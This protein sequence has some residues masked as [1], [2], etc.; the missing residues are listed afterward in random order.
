MPGLK[1]VPVD[2]LTARG[3]GLPYDVNNSQDMNG[4]P[5]LRKATRQAYV[6]ES[7]LVFRAGAH[8]AGVTFDSH[9]YRV[10]IFNVQPNKGL[11]HDIS[12]SVKSEDG[13]YVNVQGTA[14]VTSTIANAHVGYV[15][16]P[17][18]DPKTHTIKGNNKLFFNP[19]LMNF[20]FDGKNYY[21]ED[22]VTKINRSVDPKTNK[23]TQNGIPAW[24]GFNLVGTVKM[25]AFGN[26][27]GLVANVDAKGFF[28][29]KQQNQDWSMAEKGTI[30]GVQKNPQGGW[31]L[32]VSNR[33]IV[34]RNPVMITTPQGWNTDYGMIV[35]K[36]DPKDS[37][38]ITNGTMTINATKPLPFVY[39]G[40]GRI[41]SYVAP[42]NSSVI[43]EPS[44]RIGRFLKEGNVIF[45]TKEFLGGSVG[46]KVDW[47]DGQA[48]ETVVEL[49]GK[50]IS[51]KLVYPTILGGK[52][53]ALKEATG[54][55]ILN[56]YSG[57]TDNFKGSF[58]QPQQFA[59]VLGASSEARE[60]TLSIGKKIKGETRWLLYFT[61]SGF[62]DKNAEVN[63]VVKNLFAYVSGTSFA[64]TKAIEN[65]LSIN[66]VKFTPGITFGGKSVGGNTTPKYIY[67]DVRTIKLG[68]GT[69]S[70]SLW[71]QG[72]ITAS[73][74]K[75]TKDNISF[76][77]K[78]VFQITR[79]SANLQAGAIGLYL[80]T[81]GDG[82]NPIKNGAKYTETLPETHQ[83]TDYNYVNGFIRYR[84]HEDYRSENKLPIGRVLATGFSELMS[85]ELFRSYEQMTL[86]S[87]EASGFGL[88]LH[89]IG[90]NQSAKIFDPMKWTVANGLEVAGM[91]ITAGLSGYYSAAKIAQ[92]LEA[93]SGV[94]AEGA[95]TGGLLVNITSSFVSKTNAVIQMTKL[96]EAATAMTALK[97]SSVAFRIALA[98]GKAQ[99]AWGAASAGSTM[100][101]DFVVYRQID[102][103]STLAAGLNG[104]KMGFEFTLVTGTV[105]AVASRFLPATLGASLTKIADAG[106]S[107]TLSDAKALNAVSAT[108]RMAAVK[109]GAIYT[110][111]VS[112]FV[113]AK[114][115]TNPVVI[116]AVQN[117]VIN[118]LTGYVESH[119]AWGQKPGGWTINQGMKDASIAALVSLPFGL[120]KLGVVR[121]A[122]G[123]F[124]AAAYSSFAQNS[125]QVHSFYN[126]ATYVVVNNISGEIRDAGY[127]INPAKY[128]LPFFSWEQKTALRSI[129]G[130]LGGNVSAVSGKWMKRIVG[131]EEAAGGSAG[132]LQ[133]ADRAL[134]GETITKASTR[135]IDRAWGSIKEGVKS[136]GAVKG[137]TGQW[138]ILK[139]EFAASN[140][141]AWPITKVAQSAQ[142][143]I[144]PI[145]G[146]PATG[147][148]LYAGTGYVI[149]HTFSAFDDYVKNGGDIHKVDWDKANAFGIFGAVSALSIKGWNDKGRGLMSRALGITE[150]KGELSLTAFAAKP[151]LI[152]KTG[153]VSAVDFAIPADAFNMG[154][155]FADYNFG[156]KKWNESRRFFL[157]DANG[158]E[159]G[160]WTASA[161][162]KKTFF[163]MGLMLGPIL[164]ATSRPYSVSGKGPLAWAL[165]RPLAHGSLAVPIKLVAVKEAA[166]NLG[167]DKKFADQIAFVSLAFFPGVS[168]M[169]QY[170]AGLRKIDNQLAWRD[171]RPD[172][173]KSL[174]LNLQKNKLL[175]Q[176]LKQTEQEKLDFKGDTNSSKYQKLDRTQVDIQ[177]NIDQTNNRVTEYTVKV[178][179]NKANTAINKL[180]KEQQKLNE[181]LKNL[182]PKGFWQAAEKEQ[183]SKIM[184]DIAKTQNKINYFTNGKAVLEKLIAKAETVSNR[185]RSAK[186]KDVQAKE[187]QV[188]A[189]ILDIAKEIGAEFDAQAGKFKLVETVRAAGSDIQLAN[190]GHVSLIDNGTLVI[191]DPR[192]KAVGGHVG[193]GTF[194]LG[195]YA[196]DM[197]SFDHERAEL[198]IWFKFAIERN[199]MTSEEVDAL[200][201]GTLEGK[202]LG[203]RIREYANQGNFLQR[204]GRQK[205]VMN[206]F[207]VAHAEGLWAENTMPKMAASN[208]YEATID[209]KVNDIKFPKR[210]FD[211]FISSNGAA[212]SRADVQPEMTGK[213]SSEQRKAQGEGHDVTRAYA[214]TLSRAAKAIDAVAS[215]KTPE[216]KAKA[217]MQWEAANRDVKLKEAELDLHIANQ[218]LQFAE[219]RVTVEAEK[220][221]FTG[222]PVDAGMPTTTETSTGKEKTYA[223]KEVERL[224][225]KVA[226]Y[227][228]KVTVAE[229]SAKQAAGLVVADALLAGKQREIKNLTQKQADLLEKAQ[230]NP[231]KF[232]SAADA[233][234]SEIQKQ[235]GALDQLTADL[236]N[237]VSFD[238]TRRKG[239]IEKQLR[240][241]G[242]AEKQI[243]KKMGLESSLAALKEQPRTPETEK[244]IQSIEAKLSD[245][246][247]YVTPAKIVEKSQWEARLKSL[248]GKTNTPV[249]LL[250][251]Q[252]EKTT[253]EIYSRTLTHELSEGETTSSERVQAIKQTLA[254]LKSSQGVDIVEQRYVRQQIAEKQRAL[255]DVAQ[256][257]EAP[258][259]P[260]ENKSALLERKAS[261]ESEINQLKTMRRDIAD[262]EAIT[263][264][265]HL[266]SNTTRGLAIVLLEQ[267]D[268]KLE[269][270]MGEYR[271][272]ADIEQNTFSQENTAPLLKR[273]E[274]EKETRTKAHEAVREEIATKTAEIKQAERAQQ[275]T[276]IA[277]QS[278]VELET[279]STAIRAEIAQLDTLQG[280]LKRS[281]QEI[282]KAFE[283]GENAAA[284]KKFLGE[285]A[286]VKLERSVGEITQSSV[287]QKLSAVRNERASVTAQLA[288]QSSQDKLDML[289]AARAATPPSDR[290][291]HQ[292]LDLFEKHVSEDIERFASAA[293][294]PEQSDKF[295]KL[296]STLDKQAGTERE[297][298]ESKM[299]KAKDAWIDTVARQVA[300]ENVEATAWL[301]KELTKQI[302]SGSEMKDVLNAVSNP[303]V[304]TTLEAALKS[305]SLR[306]NAEQEYSANTPLTTE[307]VEAGKSSR[308]AV[309][310]KAIREMGATSFEATGTVALNRG[311]LQRDLAKEYESAGNATEASKARS[312]AHA[313]FTLAQNTGSS[314]VKVSAREQMARM[315][316]DPVHVKM[317][318]AGTLE[319]QAQIAR[320]HAADPVVIKIL[321]TKIEL[322]DIAGQLTDR[323]VSFDTVHRL[324]QRIT[325][326]IKNLPEIDA[327]ASNAVLS[328]SNECK[329]LADMAMTAATLLRE[330]LN[331]GSSSTPD[332]AAKTSKIDEILTKLNDNLNVSKTKLFATR[333]LD[334]TMEQSLLVDV[335]LNMKKEQKILSDTD[336]QVLKDLMDTGKTNSKEERHQFIAS[337]YDKINT[338]LTQ[339]RS[340]WETR[341]AQKEYVFHQL[342]YVFS[343]IEKIGANKTAGKTWAI[344]GAMVSLAMAG[345]K[346]VMEA[347][348]ADAI[349]PFARKHKLDLMIVKPSDTLAD[350]AALKTI[351]GQ[352]R[353]FRYTEKEGKLTDSSSENKI[354]VVTMQELQQITLKNKQESGTANPLRDHLAIVDEMH[355]ILSAVP[356]ITSD[357]RDPYQ[358]VRDMSQ[359]Q[360]D[361]R[362]QEMMATRGLAK[363]TQEV[364]DAF[365]KDHEHAV[366][367]FV[368]QPT[369]DN[370][371]FFTAEEKSF[372][373]VEKD[374][375]QKL[376]QVTEG[377]KLLDGMTAQDQKDAKG[378][379]EIIQDKFKS[380]M[381]HDAEAVNGVT[382]N[383]ETFMNATASALHNDIW[384]EK[385]T[386]DVKAGKL[387]LVTIQHNLSGT[388]AYNRIFTD[389]AFN[390]YSRMIIGLYEAKKGN[391]SLQEYVRL[392]EPN[393]HVQVTA[394]ETL[395][396]LGGFISGTGT[397]DIVKSTADSVRIAFNELGAKV[398]L[399]QIRFNH[400]LIT[401][402]APGETTAGRII[403][404]KDATRYESETQVLFVNQALEKDRKAILERPEIKAL[405][406]KD[407]VVVLY[408]E[409]ERFDEG[410]QDI[411]LKV[412]ED[413]KGKTYDAGSKTITDAFG[414]A[415][416]GNLKGKQI[417]FISAGE[418]GSSFEFKGKLTHYDFNMR[419]LSGFLQA[420][421]R[422]NTIIDMPGVAGKVKR[423]EVG[424]TDCEYT[425]FVNVSDVYSDP[426]LTTGQL[427]I[428]KTTTGKEQRTALI[429]IMQEMDQHES[430]QSFVQ[431]VS[432]ARDLNRDAMSVHIQRMY[433]N[434]MTDMVSQY[435]KD[436][437]SKIYAGVNGAGYQVYKK[438]GGKGFVSFATAALPGG[439]GVRNEYG[440]TD[441]E[442]NDVMVP[443][444]SGESARLYSGSNY[445]LNVTPVAGYAYNQNNLLTALQQ[446]EAADP[447]KWLLQGPMRNPS[448]APDKT[449]TVKTWVPAQQ[450]T[451]GKDELIRQTSDLNVIKADGTV[452]VIPKVEFYFESDLHRGKGL[453]KG[454]D[455]ASLAAIESVLGAKVEFLPGN[456]TKQQ[457]E[458]QV[459]VSAEPTVS[460]RKEVL[461]VLFEGSL[462]MNKHGLPTAGDLSADNQPFEFN[463]IVG[464]KVEH[465]DL[466]RDE[467]RLQQTMR[468]N[469]GFEVE[470]VDAKVANLAPILLQGNEIKFGDRVGLNID[471]TGG[472]MPHVYGKALVV[473]G[474]SYQYET[475]FNTATQRNEAVVEVHRADVKVAYNV[476]GQLKIARVS[477]Q[478]TMRP[479]SLDVGYERERLTITDNLPDIFDSKES[480]KEIKK[481]VT[482]DYKTGIISRPTAA[483]GKEK[484][485]GLFWNDQAFVKQNGEYT[486]DK[487]SMIAAKAGSLGI[488][489]TRKGDRLYSVKAADFE[490]KLSQ[491]IQSMEK[492]ERSYS[493]STTMR[494]ASFSEAK[495][496]QDQINLVG[497]AQ[498][499]IVA[500]DHENNVLNGGA[501]VEEPKSGVRYGIVLKPGKDSTGSASAFL[502]FYKEHFKKE[503]VL[504]AG[505]GD[506]AAQD[507]PDYYLI[508][509]AGVSFIKG[510]IDF[511][512]AGVPFLHEML[513]H[514]YNKRLIEQGEG[515]A[516]VQERTTREDVSH[517]A[518]DKGRNIYWEQF[519][520]E[521]T[522]AH[523]LEIN[524]IHFDQSGQP[525]IS[526]HLKE[527]LSLDASDPLKTSETID[528]LKEAKKRLPEYFFKGKI[529]FL[530]ESFAAGDTYTANKQ[531][532]AMTETSERTVFFSQVSEFAQREAIK[533]VN[534][535]SDISNFIIFD[536]GQIKARIPY[537]AQGE[538]NVHVM[539]I[540]KKIPE[541]ERRDYLLEQLKKSADQSSMYSRRF[542]LYGMI[543]QRLPEQNIKAMEALEGDGVSE[544]KG[545]L[546]GLKGEA[547]VIKAEQMMKVFGSPDIKQ[548][549]PDKFESSTGYVEKKGN[550]WEVTAF[551][552]MP[553]PK[554]LV[555]FNTAQNKIKASATEKAGSWTTPDMEF[556]AKKKEVGSR[557]FSSDLPK[558]YTITMVDPQDEKLVNNIGTYYG[559]SLKVNQD[560]AKINSLKKTLGTSNA[561]N[562][563]VQDTT[564][565]V[566]GYVVAQ[567][568]GNETLK[569]S[570]FVA[571]NNDVR[572]ALATI[573]ADRLPGLGFNQVSDNNI[574][575]TS[576]SLDEWRAMSRATVTVP[577]VPEISKPEQA[578]APD[579]G[580]IKDDEKARV[581][582]T[583]AF[584]RESGLKRLDT[585][586]KTL[587]KISAAGA[588]PDLLEQMVTMVP[589]QE[590]SP[591]VIQIHLPDGDIAVPLPVNVKTKTQAV[592][593]VKSNVPT[594]IEENKT[595]QVNAMRQKILTRMPANSNAR[596]AIENVL[597]DPEQGQDLPT[598]TALTGIFV[599][600]SEKVAMDGTTTFID[601]TTGNNV[602][603]TPGSKVGALDVKTPVSRPTYSKGQEILDQMSA[604]AALPETTITAIVAVPGQQ[605]V[606]D[607]KTLNAIKKIDGQVS[608]AIKPENKK[609]KIQ[610]V[611]AIKTLTGMAEKNLESG[612][613]H[614]SLAKALGELVKVLH[615][616]QQFET[617]PNILTQMNQNLVIA[618]TSSKIIPDNRV[619]AIKL[620]RENVDQAEAQIPDRVGIEASVKPAIS[621]ELLARRDSPEARSAVI[622]L[623]VQQGMPSSLKEAIHHFT[624]YEATVPDN[625]VTP[626]R[627]TTSILTDNTVKFAPPPASE[628]PQFNQQDTD[629]AEPHNSTMSVLRQQMEVIAELPKP[630]KQNISDIHFMAAMEGKLSSETN[631]DPFQAYTSATAPADIEAK[632]NELIKQ[633]ETKYAA[634]PKIVAE[635]IR[636]L[637]EVRNP[638]FNAQMAVVNQVNAVV[639]QMNQGIAAAQEEGDDDAIQNVL[640]QGRIHLNALAAKAPNLGDIPYYM[641]TIESQLPGEK[642]KQEMNKHLVAAATAPVILPK[643]REKAIEMI[644]A[645]LP[646]QKK[647][648]ESTTATI[649]KPQA[650][651]LTVPAA[652]KAFVA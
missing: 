110:G 372:K 258:A 424:R 507:T 161:D 138:Q 4:D 294:A 616:E 489:L 473:D 174:G 309:L 219:N 200:R 648:S 208:A 43:R 182:G 2:D 261:L 241:I 340:G 628:K 385:F 30:V 64:W 644:R 239:A 299:A 634:S 40:R 398:G 499:H 494:A 335:S 620:I 627:T 81:N 521:E 382:H 366:A 119:T 279:R 485:I 310:E 58:W 46:I 315:E 59:V 415:I 78:L 323:N 602:V 61:I 227:E 349:Q 145:L 461:A 206:A 387:D 273:I 287:Q 563:V 363:V 74:E 379:E 451:Q 474:R 256:E 368:G 36:G 638:E 317:E 48:Q 643:S 112:K 330:K 445:A 111:A 645:Q 513:I 345:G 194:Q 109:T 319:E 165:T 23:V 371:K 431:S 240:A 566:M 388:K 329:N 410:V 27:N 293:M 438:T 517:R 551:A 32:L 400:E 257:M 62:K 247:E 453:S 630:E 559:A 491:N 150:Q 143:V 92:R 488:T 15:M 234:N 575:S 231:A 611:D 582:Q 52:F 116:T 528:F 199:L 151:D 336:R 565:A 97:G 325:T 12:V 220:A 255:S 374:G 441:L 269:Q 629:I 360:R 66:T 102:G 11:Q 308:I 141:G 543:F 88:T 580:K 178:A 353:F 545:V 95:E 135:P 464:Q 54:V 197:P 42:Q 242:E 434:W 346:T 296:E 183:A 649:A 459:L 19:A 516:A 596:Q 20:T 122:E 320:E 362:T 401:T 114:A 386:T 249:E 25:D 364:V 520:T 84:T 471:K 394:L 274:I 129:A 196:H 80:T 89:A 561:L 44:K 422:G 402:S 91:V 581:A 56:L 51:N 104:A 267:K 251:A 624:Q 556:I 614:Y 115:A 578:N 128:T 292:Q 230:K 568:V 405:D 108:G 567:P 205:D 406:G 71:A 469:S 316:M 391:L 343:L 468:V 120:A 642:M 226:L 238:V 470:A 137:F 198:D 291:A 613:I 254:K 454:V 604:I 546:S 73:F 419:G 589:A 76:W 276:T 202:S 577:L 312:A 541:A 426:R 404:W 224:T 625:P 486:F 592:A 158:V 522:P 407:N 262:T 192:F 171:I 558:G 475:K 552:Y 598:L 260:S 452:A 39:H 457:H 418:A 483:K 621:K 420:A 3:Y 60:G 597:N 268:E 347:Y 498:A 500:I 176:Y 233:V 591:A 636:A 6:D 399:D 28:Y 324:E 290:Q 252:Q 187:N 440:H 652:I 503:V 615:Q 50:N 605:N 504:F 383:W 232:Q 403:S 550:S 31:S 278:V 339:D 574:T 132:L 246:P 49:N 159:S 179:V 392:T 154:M 490:R 125:R 280:V 313:D 413:V 492:I 93:F 169:A 303:T 508:G 217:E 103:D 96:S 547:Y 210:N 133:P 525:I 538:K 282:K 376:A 549:S 544:I 57:T 277:Q 101:H 342:N 600:G 149:G 397:P 367:V 599:N 433:E 166:M 270:L 593:F 155:V 184:A 134:G 33:V 409:P 527:V 106:L 361:L 26:I 65:Y 229:N 617:V 140:P 393:S 285:D 127:S 69:D 289:H 378:I 497:D 300:P 633:I 569:I 34:P 55:K 148:I 167:V 612:D 526:E 572:K 622:N 576:L 560:E 534:G 601:E 21:H 107:S 286:A 209:A 381:S 98:A 172:D 380:N 302:E 540:P 90:L 29:T 83:V 608:S 607:E 272:Q 557:L 9:A 373:W 338:N 536:D 263:Q 146:A 518:F 484:V 22:G 8:Q 369:T 326:L 647:N 425:L 623:L 185:A 180:E 610:L 650:P 416:T 466:R 529:D 79:K 248:E 442:A 189:I 537:Q 266:V 532:E 463:A 211:V 170:K 188:K 618:A 94:M 619:A 359:G 322:A 542:A 295:R 213:I 429:Q 356:M 75:T 417:V 147:Y 5:E 493:A 523:E 585:V 427:E 432:V 195:I 284:A 337:L 423:S 243:K 288:V 428:L 646:A 37:S 321:D 390:A 160:L 595:D 421:M 1:A 511:D 519:S 77:E 207:H 201:N 573:V 350:S 530:R 460:G 548:V 130:S 430:Q 462:Y 228:K 533:V 375:V 344:E 458:Y 477:G 447:K 283:T 162:S 590:H 583:K 163:T 67:Y 222:A 173:A 203:M 164:G 384:N 524:G 564:G 318:A 341:D 264:A 157:A 68:K 472:L 514:A 153:L 301:V 365:G 297:S 555:E 637:P 175:D 72:A 603:F 377:K 214:Q 352:K 253:A 190:N 331:S 281:P 244:G 414:N 502:S 304:R 38:S 332:A 142:Q 7:R 24:Y 126:I 348:I 168:P 439:T 531:A 444:P 606:S 357:G 152:W 467:M 639:A 389:K 87:G 450:F 305:E 41:D 587:E 216:A 333:L 47:I 487:D 443:T 446:G 395:G 298:H 311:I 354:A 465:R 505:L 124:S 237:S 562:L 476:D 70:D 449:L 306:I 193:R 495:N 435:A 113:F 45:Y 245:I 396:S 100:L 351:N 156:S 579:A 271:K 408:Y 478:E 334:R 571:A 641:A 131:G 14:T 17:Y 539:Y 510:A 506:S 177:Q 136:Q 481:D 204:L 218:S 480:K 221:A 181:K 358:V 588:P 609:G 327:F 512:E 259:L 553:D 186:P 640:T 437:Y 18:L 355:M 16:V 53:L 411:T 223:Q 13:Q 63:P 250:A 307:T 225:K 626:E 584:L 144:R 594:V 10:G 105:G 535:V 215:A 191:I 501:S 482:I 632:K 275:D 82:P 118:V 412:G 448:L 139:Q 265:A 651:G 236:Q 370:Y 99:Y 436:G 456:M 117:A 235:Q 328:E 496:L 479:S 509:K 121:L 35:D 212:T 515:G 314:T 631:N 570:H 85:Q 586:L 86:G 123:S 635:F 554:D 455:E